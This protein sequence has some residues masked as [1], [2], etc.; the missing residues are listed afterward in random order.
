[1]GV[2]ESVFYSASWYLLITLIGLL[3]LPITL[4]VF[5]FLPDRGY[6][7]SRIL[8]LLLWSFVYWLLAS[9]GVLYNQIGGI[10]FA[11]AVLLVL[12]LLVLQGLDRAALKIW[13]GRNR[14]MVFTAEILFATA[15]IAMIAVRGLTPDIVG[16]EKPM[17]LAFINSILNSD[18]F[19]PHDPWLSGY[20]ISYYYFGYVMVGMLAM[21][22]GASGGIAFNLGISLIFSLAAIG[23]YGLV[24]NLLQLRSKGDKTQGV[25][26]SLLGPL[27]IL[28]V[29]NLEGFLH[30]LHERGL[31]WVRGENGVLVSSFWKW[32]DIKDLNIPP[33]EP[34]SWVPDD[35]WWWWRASRVVQDYNF[36]RSPLEIIDEFPF[37]SF[38]LADLHPH[39]LSIPF[40]LL[41]A[42][43]GLNLFLFKDTFSRN[44]ITLRINLRT[45][46]WF[47]LALVPTSLLIAWAG[48][49]N[50]SLLLLGAGLLL[51]L[52]CL[53]VAWF[54]SPY[55][56]QHRWQL[57]S[58]SEIGSWTGCFDF[59]IGW[60]DL[61]VLGVT[62]GGLAFL[63]T[64][65]I[66][67]GVALVAGSFA[68]WRI[69]NSDAAVRLGALVKDFGLMSVLLVILSVLLYLPF[70]IGF[71]SQAGGPLPNL[72][73]PTRGAHFWVMFA[74]LLI[75]IFA[76]LV[77]LWRGHRE[78]VNIR[79][80]I[81]I[82]VTILLGLWVISFVLGFIVVNLPVIQGIEVGSF[83]LNFLGAPNSSALFKEAIVRRF[84]QPGGWVTM[85]AL[86][87]LLVALVKNGLSRSQKSADQD[88]R[89][90][91]NAFFQSDFFALLLILMGTLLTI[92]AEFIYL[93]D[94]F[95]WRINTIFKFYYQTW[96][97]WGIAS[98]YGTAVLLIRLK[99]PWSFI[100]RTALIL[101]LAASLVYPVFSLW[102][103]TDGFQSTNGW[104]L[105]GTAYLDLQSPGEMEAL[106][107]L[108]AAPDGVVSEA[109]SPTGGSYQWPPGYGRVSALSGKP[110]VLGW[111]GHENQWR[112]G[113]AEIGSRQPDMETLYCSRDE[114]ETIA[115]VN[116]Y[117][118]RYIF[119]G[120]LE[121]S[122][123]QPGEG[124]CAAGIVDRK[125]NQLM[126]VAFQNDQVI[127]Y[128]VAGFQK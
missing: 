96:L 124:V 91:V 69:Y 7:F 57:F 83:Y 12:S 75:P 17:E 74:P 66:L 63:N 110:G 79:N 2:S 112:G 20:A 109:V 86:I 71:S 62:V 105:D 106:R 87:S 94:Q 18:T 116:Q 26:I 82:G 19:P 84:S 98:A 122:T 89:N 92:G 56:T 119:I 4:R 35:F 23:A 51:L 1:M 8:G 68:A 37:F 114:E 16:T 127:I 101:L 67:I 117:N 22:T 47:V 6:T 72:I 14:G 24:F 93:R 52:G 42:A 3:T 120:P 70:Y 80:G 40:M 102:N 39:V 28:I 128:E 115:V 113:S 41:V 61:L 48:I 13:W 65:D 53:G 118:I 36:L 78:T 46:S 50:L 43:F 121:R 44:H 31:F 77:Y 49:M 99:P 107:W 58:S 64:W 104:S 95:G 90:Q 76:F 54:L 9:L 103:K 30:S 126:D 125:F 59:R 27:F 29:S 38:L 25:F 100:F 85:L 34:F 73:F 32:L 88:E 33:T 5:R 60:I 15:F 21:I 11:V 97:V 45:I 10:L 55:I 111:I 108:E 123:Y 81:A